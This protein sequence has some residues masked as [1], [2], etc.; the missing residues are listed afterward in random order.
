M[1]VIRDVRQTFGADNLLFKIIAEIAVLETHLD[2]K[3]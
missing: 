2:W 3:L 1:S